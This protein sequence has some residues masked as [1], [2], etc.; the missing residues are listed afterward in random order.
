MFECARVCMNTTNIDVCVSAFVVMSVSELL[1][2]TLKLMLKLMMMM[3]MII[4][5]L[6][7]LLLLLLPLLLIVAEPIRKGFDAVTLATGAGSGGDDR[8]DKTFIQSDARN[9]R[10]A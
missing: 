4:L 7:M 9:T 5:L 6:L 3:M 1:W 10:I 8:Y 2:L